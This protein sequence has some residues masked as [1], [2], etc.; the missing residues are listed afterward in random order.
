MLD[1]ELGILDFIQDK[2]ACPL[3]DKIMPAISVLGD[4]GIVCIALAVLLLIFRKTRP[5]GLSIGFALLLGFLCG[6][7]AI[8]NIVARTRPYEYNSEIQLLVEKLTDYSFPSG[9]SLAVFETA[10]CVFIRYKKWGVFALV[11]AILVAFS[12]LYLYV[13]FPSDV[14]AG[15]LMGIIFGIIGSAITNRIYKKK[16]TLSKKSIID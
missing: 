12:R 3:L 6:N 11:L 1:F 2:L 8:K 9:H 13:H 14:L 15:I 4:K 16:S 7:M 5:L 10:T